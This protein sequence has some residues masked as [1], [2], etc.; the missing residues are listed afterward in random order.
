MVKIVSSAQEAVADIFDGAIIM[1][2]GFGGCGTPLNLTAAIIERGITNLTVICNNLSDCL[3]LAQ[4][5]RIKKAIISFPRIP[6]QSCSPLVDGYVSGKVEI[7]IASLGILSERIRAYG[8][9][10]A[11]FYTRVGAGTILA[12]GKESRVFDG[13]EFIFERALGAD[14]ALIK[15]FKADGIGNLIYRK[16]ARN[17]NPI[18]A[19]ASG[20][21][22]AEVE[23]IVEVGELDPEIV[24]TPGLFVDRLVR[25]EKR[26]R[27][28]RL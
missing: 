14:F 1:V 27:W 24:V 17:N 21:T 13:E 8:A 23:E 5:K 11:G 6:G 19:M 16:A 26:V 9:G 15:A 2:G 28:F 3:D 12:E 10:L 4:E 22:I 20:V 7:E 18:M 25:A